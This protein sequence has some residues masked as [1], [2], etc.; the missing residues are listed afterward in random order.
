MQTK[1]QTRREKDLAIIAPEIY[2]PLTSPPHRK[3]PVLVLPLSTTPPTTP[4]VTAKHT[5]HRP[6]PPSMADDTTQTLPPRIIE[7][8]SST[9][10]LY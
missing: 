8:I 6:E 5:P 1:I 2:P 9:I 3:T 10:M 4:L 7:N